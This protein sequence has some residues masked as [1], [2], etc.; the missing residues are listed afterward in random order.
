MTPDTTNTIG[1]ESRVREV[2]AAS[3]KWAAP[4]TAAEGGSGHAARWALPGLR[5]AG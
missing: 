2:V 4:G 1:T 3:D 5:A